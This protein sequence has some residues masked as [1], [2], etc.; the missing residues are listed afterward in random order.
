[1]KISH[2]PIALALLMLACGP[3]TSD[4]NEGNEQTA[5]VEQLEKDVFAVH[6]DVMPRI[7][8]I[9]KLKKEL[10]GK[11]ASLDSLQQA[12]P[13]EAVRIDEQKEQGRLIVRR[14]TEADSLMRDWM[15]HY[16][17]DTLKALPEADAVRYLNSQK[18]IINDVKKKINQSVGDAQAYLK[19]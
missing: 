4:K 9:M 7:S 18:E 3:S 13:S 2:Y 8:D 10:N 11:L 15:H 14:L 5:S 1:M 17:S 16:N 6:D 12:S 19:Q